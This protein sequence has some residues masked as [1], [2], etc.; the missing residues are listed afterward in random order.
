MLGLTYLSIDVASDL[1]QK[2]AG[3]SC[4]QAIGLVKMGKNLYKEL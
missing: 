1:P 3:R 2:P 4:A